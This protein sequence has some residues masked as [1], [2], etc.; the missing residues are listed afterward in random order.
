MAQI[1]CLQNR[2]RSWTWRTDLCLP[3][4]VGETG[5]LMGVWNWWEQTITLGRDGQWG[6]AVQHR[7][8]YPVSWVRI[9]WKQTMGVYGQ[10]YHFAI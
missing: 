9:Q 3:D 1:I 7:E 8:L 6:L 10:A 2:N 5:G 4:R